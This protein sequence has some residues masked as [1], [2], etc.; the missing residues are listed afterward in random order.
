M[1]TSSTQRFSYPS[2]WIESFSRSGDSSSGGVGSGGPG[3]GRPGP[4]RGK[5]GG[6]GIGGAMHPRPAIESG[7]A[8]P[9]SAPRGLAGA[10]AIGRVLDG[11]PPPR[12]QLQPR[13]GEKENLRVRLLAL[14]VVA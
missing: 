3:P 2:P 10:K 7:Q 5:G 12:L 4:D 8:P 1:T 14:R 13:G 6:G 9:A 11:Q